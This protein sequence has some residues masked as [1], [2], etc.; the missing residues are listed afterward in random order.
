MLL[1]DWLVGRF[2]TD[3]EETKIMSVLVNE[4]TDTPTDV[5][6]NQRDRLLILVRLDC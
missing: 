5:L 3:K 2:I 1:V 6:H 4:H